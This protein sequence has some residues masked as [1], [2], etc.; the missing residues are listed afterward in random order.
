MVGNRKIWIVSVRK[1]NGSNKP[2]QW[3]ATAAKWCAADVSCSMIPWAESAAA[4][5]SSNYNTDGVHLTERGAKLRAEMIA[6]I[7]IGP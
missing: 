4:G 6:T 3:N 2:K 7:V 5:R 1:L